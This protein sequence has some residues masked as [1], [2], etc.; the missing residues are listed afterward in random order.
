MS[1]NP[2]KAALTETGMLV[3]PV[4]LIA[5]INKS[6]IAYFRTKRDKGGHNLPSDAELALLIS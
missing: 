4:A 3:T 2:R 6:N 1:N 5:G